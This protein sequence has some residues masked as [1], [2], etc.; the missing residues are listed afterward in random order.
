MI[1]KLFNITNSDQKSL[2]KKQLDEIVVMATNDSDEDFKL[3]NRIERNTNGVCPKCKNENIVDKIAQVV[4]DGSVGG[5]FMFGFGSVF[6]GSKI[7][8]NEVNHCSDCGHQWKKYEPRFNFI[9]DILYGYL[10]DICTYHE[11]GSEWAAKTIEKLKPYHAETIYE[12]F[13]E[14]GH[15]CY[16]STK[17][18]IK[19]KLLRKYFTSIFDE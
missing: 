9:S 15:G 7:D 13:K 12:L 4:G 1:K 2:I 16:Y 17:E 5:D 3:K 8:T 6:G 18:T 11:R 10:N 19:L 14:Y